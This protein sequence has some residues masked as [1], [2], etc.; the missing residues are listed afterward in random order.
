MP[1]DTLATQHVRFQKYLAQFAELDLPQAKSL[2]QEYLTFSILLSV[3]PTLETELHKHC[4]Q[5][6]ST[7][8]Q[9]SID[10]WLATQPAPLK[11][12][13]EQTTIRALKALESSV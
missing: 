13:V 10:A 2:L 5:V 9:A 12:L 11:L 4:T 8:D 7:R 3:L 1:T 6:F